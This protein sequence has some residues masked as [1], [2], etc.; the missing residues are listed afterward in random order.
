MCF[1]GTRWRDEK[2]GR[3][4]NTYCGPGGV[5]EASITTLNKTAPSSGEWRNKL[6]YVR[7]WAIYHSALKR[8]ELSSRKTA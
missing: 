7:Q 5:L 6:R 3:A 4:L 8:N 1:T 2:K